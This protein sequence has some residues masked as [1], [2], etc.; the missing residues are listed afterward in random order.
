[1][2]LCLIK[3]AGV[4]M[5]QHVLT[6]VGIR[7]GVRKLKLSRNSPSHPMTGL[8]C[9]A[10]GNARANAHHL[11]LSLPIFSFC[12]LEKGLVFGFSVVLLG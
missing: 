8:F 5:A 12:F 4:Y 7:I 10:K 9:A 3:Q 11:Q 6:W 2:T 1:M